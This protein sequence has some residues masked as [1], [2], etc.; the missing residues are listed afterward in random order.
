L[1]WKSWRKSLSPLR[2]I[3]SC[4]FGGKFDDMVKGNRSKQPPALPSVENVKPDDEGG[5]IARA[6][7]N[8]QDEIAVGFLID[9]PE[10]PSL[11]KVHCETH[12]DVVLVHDGGGSSNR[13]AEFVQVK[14]SAPDKLWSVADLC[15]RKNG[16]VGTSVLEIS[17]SRD[18]C[19]ETSRFRLVTLRPVVSGLK[20]LTFPL[21][22]PGRRV[23]A[24]PFKTLHADLDSRFPGLNSPKGNGVNYWVKNCLWDQRHSE[25]AVRNDNRVRLYV[26]VS[27]KSYHCL[28]DQQSCFWTNCKLSRR[29]L[30]MPGGTL[31]VTRK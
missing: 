4:R 12:D 9:M 6:G 31:I 8:Y 7:F 26:R 13:L 30:E 18:K 19:R 5:P 14:A 16:R 27:K 29:P 17:I 20:I 2:Q 10:N 15:V 23:D 21:A 28:R 1:N 11:L 22:T 3:S 25:E 24:K